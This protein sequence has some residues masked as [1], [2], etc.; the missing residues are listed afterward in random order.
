MKI[1]VGL[2]NVG[3]QYE[4][5]RHNAGFL[6]IDRLIQVWGATETAG[7]A[8]GEIWEVNRRGQKILLVKPR[9]FMNQSGKCVGPLMKFYK[10]KPTDLIVIHDEL[11]LPP[12][13]LRVK[14][15]GGTAG[16]N[17]LKSLDQYLGA[18]NTGYHRLRIG[19]GKPSTGNTVDYVLHRF[20]DEDLGQL[21]LVLDQVVRAAELLIEDRPNQAM[22]EFNT[23]KKK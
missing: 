4:T 13:S 23:E 15:G 9:T 7:D 17:G 18:D 21:D 22:L 5:T 11:D 6:G 19:I 2:G 10:C 12:L 14:T 16:H 1:I 3:P 8:D 20:T